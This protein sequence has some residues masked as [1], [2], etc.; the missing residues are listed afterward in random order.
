MTPAENRQRIKN[1]ALNKIIRIHNDFKGTYETYG[2]H[3]SF[4]EQRD[5]AVELV[6][7]EMNTELEKTKHG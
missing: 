5:Y 1:E 7:S 3:E 2:D 6:I 4:R